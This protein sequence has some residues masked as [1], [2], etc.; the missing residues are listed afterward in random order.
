[1]KKPDAAMIK[2]PGRAYLQVGNDEIYEL[3]QSAFS[4]ADYVD[5]E[6]MN[7][8]TKKDHKIYSIALNGKS[9]KIYPQVEEKI[10]EKQCMTQ[11]ESMVDYIKNE[12]KENGIIALEGPWKPSLS[13][14]VPL[15]DEWKESFIYTDDDKLSQ[16]VP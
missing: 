15:K 16:K 6:H 11:L 9:E 5:T 14:I 1:L 10:I 3:F 8:E 7:P 12:A 13:E 2:L 4:G